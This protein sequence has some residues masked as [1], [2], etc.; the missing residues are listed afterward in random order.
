MRMKVAIVSLFALF[1]TSFA[2]AASKAWS[3][4]LDAAFKKAEK[5]DKNVLVEFTGSDWC[6]PCIMMNKKVFSKEE[7]TDSASDDFILVKI[8]IPKGDKALTERNQPLLEKYEVKGVPTV[9]LFDSEGEEYSRFVAS[10]YPTVE[11]FLA[12]LKEVTPAG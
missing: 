9:I 8:D 4:D 7:F 6:P 11:G 3:A 1:L 12:H 10:S 5:E 2:A